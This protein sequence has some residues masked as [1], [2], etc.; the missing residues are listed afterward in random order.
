MATTYTWSWTLL[1]F[2][3]TWMVFHLIKRKKV[4]TEEIE[5]EAE[6][7]RDGEADVIIVGAGVAGAALAYA[8]AKDGR[9]VHVIE[10][11]L[12][13]PQRFMGEL[14]QPG[15]RLMLAQLGLEDCL[16]EI[17]AQEIKS[18]AIYK[19]GKNDTLYFPNNKKFPYEPAGRLLRNGRL[20]QRLRKKAAS[21]VNVQLEEGTVKSLIEEKGV[22][23]GVI[24]KNSAGENITAFAPLTVVCDGCY[25]NLR[26]SAV[27]N[28]EEVLSYFVGYVTKNTRLEDPH[29][30]H[31][32]FSKPLPCVVYHITSNEVRCAAE[33]PA[34]SIPSMANGE[35]V[36]YL[37]NT[38]APQIPDGNLRETFLKGVE[39]GLL[40]IK[41]TA[42]KSM[43]AKPCDKKG[44][45][46]L[47]DAFNM[48]HPIIASGMMVALSDVLILRNLLRPL[49]SFSNAKKVL[50]LVKS[51]YIIRKPMSATVNTLAH[52]FSEVLVAT[53]DEAREGMRQS[54][55]KY[56]SSG[57]F[58]TSGMM[59]I[60]G[61]MNPRPLTLVFH[62]VCIT[63]TAMGHLLSPFP[64]PRRFWHSLRVFALA[65][66]MLGKHL[67]DE[68]L[69]EMLIPINA[70][71]YRRNYMATASDC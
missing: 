20:V 35:M 44:V 48:R 64:S 31:L 66:K 49:P 68:G 58:R 38:L 27:D 21:H 24:Y 6:E 70:A 34:D 15:G 17:D 11:D 47:G 10:R 63:L 2:I 4:G 45:I 32:I 55:F 69:K 12:K 60:L 29:S 28:K 9:R 53:T 51:F 33:V 41:T 23:K 18:L 62:L 3:L 57:G 39:E 67:G 16:E 26:R 42:T 19:D 25:S 37:K 52:V 7:T 65:L 71:S 13:E 50:E 30:M 54:C 43:S 36:N 56:L 22:V 61:G 5:V 40:E 1:A 59:A 46:V 8:L 14:M